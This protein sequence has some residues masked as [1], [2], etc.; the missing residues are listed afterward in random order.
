LNTSKDVTR[1]EPS[2]LARQ[3]NRIEFF[4]PDPP[5]EEISSR[6]LDGFL[7][8]D[9]ALRMASD[10]HDEARQ[11]IEERRSWDPFGD[12]ATKGILGNSF[13]TPDPAKLEKLEFISTTFGMREAMQRLRDRATIGLDAWLE[14][15]GLLFGKVFPTWA[16][17]IRSHDVSRGHVRFN[18]THLIAKEAPEVFRQAAV[19]GFLRHNLGLVYGELAFHHPFYDG[20]GRSLNTVFTEMLRRDGLRLDWERLEPDA[21]LAALTPAVRLRD[22]APLEAFLGDLINDI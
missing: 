11:P 6:M 21:Y 22:Y 13:G 8:V 10:L 9:E 18:L 16:G 5:L 17:R 19:P 1:D 2:A 14:T 12:R 3:F 7:T 4:D 20:N 15:H